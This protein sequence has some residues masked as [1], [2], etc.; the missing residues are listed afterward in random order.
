MDKLYLRIYLLGA[1]AEYLDELSGIELPQYVTCDVLPVAL[2]D[3]PE[4]VPNDRDAV[5]L[6]SDL[7]VLAHFLSPGFNLVNL[8]FVGSEDELVNAFGAIPEGVTEV[9]P[10]ASSAQLARHLRHLVNDLKCAY[11]AW[12]Y[13]TF[14]MSLIDSLPDIIWFK[15]ANGL[16]N[17]VNKE[18]C[19]TVGKTRE[20]VKDRDHCYIWNAPP[21]S[22]YQCQETDNAVMRLGETVVADEKVETH[23]TLKQFT[24]YKSPVFGRDGE[25]IGT[26]GFGHDVTDFTNVGIEMSILLGN[27][28]YPVAIADRSWTIVR[29]NRLFDKEFG[30]FVGDPESFDYQAWRNS[31]VS[32]VVGN[33]ANADGDSKTYYLEVKGPNGTRC[34]ELQEPAIVDYFGNLSGHYC[35]FTDVTERRNYQ[36]RIEL[37]ANTDDLTGLANRRS[38][39]ARLSE[40]TGEPFTLLFLDLDRFKRVNDEL[41]HAKGDEVLRATAR[42]LQRVMPDAFVARHGGDEFACVL[43][44]SYEDA[45]LHARVD[46]LCERFAEEL[47]DLGVGLGVSVGFASSD[48]TLSDIDGLVSEADLMMYRNKVQHHGRE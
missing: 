46:E 31:H 44:G 28:P 39:Y 26:V 45:E 19:K 41:G 5:V 13:R 34:Y 22:A 42:L 32:G 17:L 6:T 47:S 16:H 3:A 27:L 38:F 12:L 15:E 8:V 21:E 4:L 36:R 10:S 20:D 37:A 33:A 40:L 1:L 25:I 29:T 18:F 14:L 30:S 11:D 2:A 35:L 24:T 7:A 9:W 43:R 23:G 48:G